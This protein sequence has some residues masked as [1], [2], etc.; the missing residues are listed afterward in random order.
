M[1]AALGLLGRVEGQQLGALPLAGGRQLEG[2]LR[3]DD[4]RHPEL[5]DL[6]REALTQN[7]GTGRQRARDLAGRLAVDEQARFLTVVDQGDVGP[8]S[9]R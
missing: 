8:G 6:A 7:G 1:A 5:V 3:Q 9:G 4:A 2:G